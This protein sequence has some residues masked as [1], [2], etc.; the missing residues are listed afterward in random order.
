MIGGVLSLLA[1]AGSDQPV[2][3]IEGS[4][5]SPEQLTATRAA[6]VR[7]TPDRAGAKQILFGDL[8]V[9]T[10]YSLDAFLYTLPLLG[11]M[12]T[13]PPADACDFARHCAALDFFS[14][15]DHARSMTPEHWKAEKESVRECSARAGDPT[16]P[17]LVV[18]HGW[19]WTQIGVTPETHYGH[20]NVIF[21]GLEED[22][23]P[24]RPI[25]SLGGDTVNDILVVARG[26]SRG[27]FVD[28]LN[29]RSYANVEWLVKSLDMV[30]RCP[31]GVPTREL[32]PDCHENAPT[33]EA[34]FAKLRE[35]DL[36]TIVIP[37]GNTWGNYTPPRSSWDKELTARM[38]DPQRQVLVEVSSGHGNSEEYRRWREFERGP[39]GEAVCPEPTAEYLPCCWRAGEIMR[40]RCGDLSPV[41]CEARVEE[42][43]RLVMEAGTAPDEVFPGTT[44][45]DWLDCG[46]CRDCFKPAY[47]Y[48][49][50]GSAQYALSL[51]NFEAGEGQPLRFRFGFISSSDSHSARA[52]TG[53]K[54]IKHR[55]L[56]DQVGP[57]SRFYAR[58]VTRRRKPEDPQ[59][60]EAVEPGTPSPL[61][62]ERIASFL[63]PG[64]TVAVHSAGRDRNSIWQGLTR[65]EV[66]GTSGPRIL[67]WFDLL[68]SPGGAAP[69]GSEVALAEPPRFEVNAVGAFVQ[70]PG[71]PEDVFRTLSEERVEQLCRNA[72]YNP[73]DTRH[74]IAAI[75]VVR[76]RPQ[77]H[78]GEPVDDLIEDP[79]RRF[80]CKPD[81]TGCV[82]QFEDPEFATSGRDAVYYV[83]ALQE[84]TPSLNAGNLRTRF[85][86]DGR[87][88]SVTP[89]F[90]GYRA[91]EGDNCLE[92]AQERAWSS[93]IFVSQAAPGSSEPTPAER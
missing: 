63:Y 73:S 38:H 41:E 75:E 48:R 55:D 88:I 91:T 43:K 7:V 68:N 28:P 62:A 12:G 90:I 44:A 84:E 49:P 79:W 74:Q 59:R 89:C 82:V 92:P 46:Q 18:F 35:W 9:H 65:R 66:Y 24:T 37:H 25:S 86:E 57:R 81:P 45:D 53:Y 21:R 76:I 29:W 87:P 2:G 61:R 70:K 34:L 50:L 27:K 13:N 85:D 15:T 6:Q 67:L 51:T 11:G 47:G 31:A 56:V 20:K 83:R 17:D 72:C 80:E 8:H 64:G 54:Q 32:P 5:R 10:S 23:V 22:E 42:A 26:A 19:E 16:N 4:A 52:A 69:M 36:D 77:A 60:P 3:E 71:C 78:A 30:P 33:P 39:N 1:C 14:I 40:K 58:F 93:P